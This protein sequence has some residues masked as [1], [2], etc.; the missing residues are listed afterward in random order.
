M[1]SF[2]GFVPIGVVIVAI[3]FGSA[4]LA[5]VAAHFLPPQHL[6][7][8][9]KGVVSVSAAVVGT[10]SALVVGLLISNSSAS[11]TSKTQDIRAVV[12][13]SRPG[14]D[15]LLYAR[16]GR[17]GP[18]HPTLASADR[19]ESAAQN[20]RSLLLFNAVEWANADNGGYHT[21]R[22]R[23]LRAGA[24]GCICGGWLAI[25][26]RLSEA[27]SRTHATGVWMTAFNQQ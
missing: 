11:F 10:M 23:R 9:T 1:S 16:G 7:A 15:V 19:K 12:C 14:A 4:M 8:E 13:D 6:S 18:P 20:V 26:V 25:R 21:Q 5:M 24:L 22:F 27:T 17:D 3:L 2:V